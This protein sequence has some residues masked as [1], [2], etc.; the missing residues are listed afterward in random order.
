VAG[1][2]V[3]AVPIGYLVAIFYDA[4]VFNNTDSFFTRTDSANLKVAILYFF[5]LVQ[6]AV[7]T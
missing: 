7:V 4:L 3:A 5:L 1:L 6:N 2:F